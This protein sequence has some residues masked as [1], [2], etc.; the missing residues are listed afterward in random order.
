MERNAVS[1]MMQLLVRL[2]VVDVNVLVAGLLLPGGA[3]GPRAGR[4]RGRVVVAEYLVGRGA[5]VGRS[6]LGRAPQGAG[7]AVGQVGAVKAVAEGPKRSVDIGVKVIALRARNAPLHI[8]GVRVEADN[9][10][11]AVKEGVSIRA[12]ERRVLLVKPGI[13]PGSPLPL[14]LVWMNR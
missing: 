9:R 3:A 4:L 8:L 12:S 13:L 5:Q 1:H 10:A 11:Q 2:A 14:G 7:R 6:L